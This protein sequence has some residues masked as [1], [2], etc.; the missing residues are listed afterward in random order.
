MMAPFYATSYSALDTA[1]DFA[2]QPRWQGAWKDS[3]G[4]GTGAEPPPEFITITAKPLQS[5]TI[6]RPDGPSG[7]FSPI[8]TLKTRPCDS[9]DVVTTDRESPPAASTS[10]PGETPRGSEGPEIGTPH[11]PPLPDSRGS[12]EGDANAP[13][14]SPPG[15][16]SGVRAGP[17]TPPEP[18]AP[19]SSTPAAPG[20]PPL[21]SG[22]EA[23][24]SGD[25]A[26]SPGGSPT[27]G[28]DSPGP[29]S[30]TSPTSS[31][32]ASAQRKL[33]LR[34]IPLF[35][36]HKTLQLPT[37]PP[38]PLS[39]RGEKARMEPRLSATIKVTG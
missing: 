2:A 6:V 23:G 27:A 35:S 20:S 25:K 7:A 33:G 13:P 24:E 5:S 18:V 16:T 10:P 38:S 37:S 29:A 17:P 36:Q 15:D 34:D 32:S 31:D 30:P 14:G 9:D 8:P 4:G 3:G 21:T 12:E 19:L 11:L 28:T 22:T 1:N 26:A 39:A